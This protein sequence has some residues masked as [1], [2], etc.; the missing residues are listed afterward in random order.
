LTYHLRPGTRFDPF[1]ILGGGV[2]TNSGNTPNSVM[3]GNYQFQFAFS[4]SSFSYRQTDTVT[5]HGLDGGSR[6]VAIIG[7]GIDKALSAHS[8]LRFSARLAIGPNRAETTTDASPTTQTSTPQLG[9]FFQSRATT[10]IINNGLL[11]STLS[12]PTLNG[13]QTFGGTGLRIESTITAG[14]FIRF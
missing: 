14:Y 11:P 6:P 2:L 4:G 8:G 10:I 12:G 9:L 3:T 1:V 7:G 5:I 13:F